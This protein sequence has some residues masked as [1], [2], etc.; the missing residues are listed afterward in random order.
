MFQTDWRLDDVNRAVAH[1]RET[2]SDVTN[3]SAQSRDRER[4]EWCSSANWERTASQENRG[5]VK[6]A[7]GNSFAICYLLFAILVPK[8]LDRW[9]I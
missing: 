1:K 9:S 3:L 4:Q 6:D 7:G 5:S 2:P 8:V